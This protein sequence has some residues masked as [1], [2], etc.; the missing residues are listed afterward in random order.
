MYDRRLTVL[1]DGNVSTSATPQR[2]LAERWRID[3]T[4]IKLPE[5]KLRME[6]SPSPQP[7]TVQPTVIRVDEKKPAPME[8]TSS[9][10]PTAQPPAHAT[11]A[12]NQPANGNGNATNGGTPGGNQAAKGC[13]II[14]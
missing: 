14:L 10:N 5:G 13:C 12:A 3:I 6:A 4:D 7:T 2:D 8:T 11:M 1:A 9:P